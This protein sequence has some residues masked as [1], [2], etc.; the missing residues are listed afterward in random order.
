MILT[1]VAAF[2]CNFFEITYYD[3]AGGSGSLR[4][5]LWQVESSGYTG[6]LDDDYYGYCAGWNQDYY[7]DRPL[8][9]D[10]LDGAMKAAR[11]FGMMT[12]ILSLLAFILIMI[13]ACVSY[14]NHDQFVKVV[15]AIL[16]FLGVFTILDLVSEYIRVT[17]IFRFLCSKP[18]A[19]IC[20]GCV[21][22]RYLQKCG[23]LCAPGI[24]YCGDCG[25]GVVV[26]V[27]RPHV[28]SHEEP[29]TNAR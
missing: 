4:V 5:G 27:C 26:R 1:W 2:A 7:Y 28:C 21:G 25:L 3:S 11:A 12:S 10:N 29:T 14:G 17:S 16:V 9:S 6:T 8:N 19:H 24:R 18:R 22:F 13:P 15:A 23:Q 20:L